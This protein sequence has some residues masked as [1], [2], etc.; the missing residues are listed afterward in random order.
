MYRVNDKLVSVEVRFQKIRLPF[1][2]M[3][4]RSN[5]IDFHAYSIFITWKN[6]IISSFV[7]RGCSSC[8]PY[9][10]PSKLP[11]NGLSWGGVSLVTMI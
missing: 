6:T 3:N 8:T 11:T 2:I 7:T 1:A 10:I 5:S 9:G 4:L